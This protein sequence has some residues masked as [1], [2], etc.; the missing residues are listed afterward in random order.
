[1]SSGEDDLDAGWDPAQHAL[2]CPPWR[3]RLGN[4]KLGP[5]YGPKGADAMTRALVDYEQSRAGGGLWDPDAKPGEVRR[6]EKRAA[7]R[8]DLADVSD[9]V[10]AHSD[11]VPQREVEV[12]V[13]YWL[14]QKS[15]RVTA[16]EMEVGE[17]SV[18]QW[19]HRLR[20]RVKL[21]FCQSLHHTG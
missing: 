12:W 4:G 13:L 9:Y 21:H 20:T 2:Y 3:E 17:G 10:R 5:W 15:V 16:R 8:H 18:R 11:D 6:E 14:E 1:V 19:I 7:E